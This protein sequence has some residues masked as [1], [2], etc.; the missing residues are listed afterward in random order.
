MNLKIITVLGICFVLGLTSLYFVNDWYRSNYDVEKFQDMWYSK[1]FSQDRDK[2]FLM[3]SSHV[4]R[5]MPSAIQEM[6]LKEGFDY[7]IYNLGF[8]G[9]SHVSKKKYLEKIISIHPEIIA[10]G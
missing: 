5:L 8:P 3:G 10:F 2:I 4:V 6:L 7:D 9:D 1:S